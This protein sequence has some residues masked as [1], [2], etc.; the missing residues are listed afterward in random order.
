PVYVPNAFTPNGD[1]LN[2]TFK[3]IITKPDLISQYHLS[4][5][6][7]WGQCFFETSDPSKSWDGK[8]ELPGAYNWVVSYKDGMGKVNQLKGSVTLIK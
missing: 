1:G 7:R 2:D 5:Y 3:P 6:N 8:D 4:I